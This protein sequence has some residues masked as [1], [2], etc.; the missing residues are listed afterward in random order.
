MLPLLN[1]KI[2]HAVFGLLSISPHPT[3]IPKF[4]HISQQCGKAPL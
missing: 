1:D 3:F 4:G 2:G